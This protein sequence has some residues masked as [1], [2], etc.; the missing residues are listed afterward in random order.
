MANKVSRRQFLHTAS[1]SALG[2]AMAGALVGCSG[3]SGSSSTASASGTY[4]PGSYSAT[5][6]GISSD[7]TV[8]MIL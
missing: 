1:I 3:S 6:K 8:T 7:V 2:A 5:S 4:T